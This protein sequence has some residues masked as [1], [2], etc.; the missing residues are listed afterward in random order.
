MKNGNMC[1]RQIE[2]NDL[3]KRIINDI[4]SVIPDYSFAG[5]HFLNRLELNHLPCEYDQFVVYR[6]G[7]NYCWL[8]R[9]RGVIQFNRQFHNYRSLVEDIAESKIASN[10]LKYAK[11]HSRQ[12]RDIKRIYCEHYRTLKEQLEARLLQE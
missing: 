3:K 10:A 4:R 6:K 8:Y 5:Y 11:E 2:D 7:T 12:G 1:F 9:E